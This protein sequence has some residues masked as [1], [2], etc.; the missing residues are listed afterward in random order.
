MENIVVF[1]YHLEYFTAIWYNLW[2]FVIFWCCLVFFTF[3]V[4][5][6]Q[7]K[8]GNPD[9]KLPWL[10]YDFKYLCLDTCVYQSGRPDEFGKIANF[11]SKL[12]HNF[13]SVEKVP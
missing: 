1:Y 12:M 5:L 2:P 6:D 9:Q 11:L 13:V 3:L 8:S 4:C 7:G 10:R